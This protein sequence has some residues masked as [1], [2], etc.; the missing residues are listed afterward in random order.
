MSSWYRELGTLYYYANRPEE[1]EKVL[2]EA[3]TNF[4]KLIGDDGLGLANLSYYTACSIAEGMLEGAKDL[5]GAHEGSGPGRTLCP[6]RDDLAKESG[7]GE[8][9]LSITPASWWRTYRTIH[10][11]RYAAAERIARE[12]VRLREMLG[13]EHEW[14]GHARCCLLLALARQGKLDE[15]EQTVH[16]RLG[17]VAR[18]KREWPSSS[19]CK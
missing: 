4:R 5:E 7:E 3:V 15:V 13:I 8:D 1:A 19:G 10:R 9:W 2:L 16:D 14:T 6:R 12:A 18:P 17:R 11:S